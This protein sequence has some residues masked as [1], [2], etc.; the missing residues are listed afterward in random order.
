[1]DFYHEAN[2]KHEKPQLKHQKNDYEVKSLAQ[3][4]KEMKKSWFGT[5]AYAQTHKT[6][7]FL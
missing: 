7:V 4:V 1:M 6:A 2:K 5:F 3:R